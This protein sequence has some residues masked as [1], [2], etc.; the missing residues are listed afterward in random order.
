MNLVIL[1]ENEDDLKM[2][3]LPLNYNQLYSKKYKKII[4]N[5][6]H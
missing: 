2:I 3:V 5:Y 1:F 6:L 4:I